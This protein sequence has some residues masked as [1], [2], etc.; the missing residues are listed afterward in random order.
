MRRIRLTLGLLLAIS[1]A[2]VTAPAWANHTGFP[3]AGM[4]IVTTP[5]S[6]VTIAP[7]PRF[8]VPPSIVTPAPQAIWV[9]AH[10]AWDGLRWVWVP[11]YWFFP[12]AGVYYRN[13]CQ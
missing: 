5:P 3:R 11:G 1:L 2:A 4:R 12:G 9:P 13:P 8:V 7:A 6:S 10:W